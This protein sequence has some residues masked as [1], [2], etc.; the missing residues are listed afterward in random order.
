L[1]SEEIFNL[2]QITLKKNCSRS[3]TLQNRP[4]RE[5]LLKG[6]IRCS[7]CGLPMWAQTYHS[8]IPYYREYKYSRSQCNYP[9]A[10]GTI[11][12]H[13]P[14]EQI[15]KIIEAIELGPKCEEVLALIS[16]KDEV[17]RVKKDK[18]FKKNSADWPKLIMI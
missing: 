3:K 16:L 11:T 8:G 7:Y 18:P 10:G 12:C 5:Y 9:A 14:D 17:E 1:I 6:I 4:E 2:V 15:G 13:I